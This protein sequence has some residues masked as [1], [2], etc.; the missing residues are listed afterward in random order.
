MSKQTP[1]FDVLIIGG[2]PAGLSLA[3][4][5][6]EHGV[7]VACIDREARQAQLAP[8]F[9]GRTVAISY[10]SRRILEA[11][12]IWAAIDGQ[13]CPI[14]TIRITD[15][16][17]P[18]LVEF[19]HTD[20]P[21]PT[22][23]WIV[24]NRLLRHALFARAAALETVTHIAPATVT[25]L[26]RDEDSVTTQLADGRHIRARLLI[27]ADG[28]GSFVR[29]WM[30]IGTRQWSYKQRAI[31]CTVEHDNPHDFIALENFRPEGPFAV[32]PMT[33]GANGAH[34]SSVVWTE[35]GPERDS[36]Y[37]LD[38]ATFNAAL[39]ARFP[40]FYGSVRQIGVRGCYPL[41]LI[42]AHNYT[43]PR[44]A[45]VGD[46]AHGIH[47]IAG[48]GLNLGFRD[49]AVIAELIVDA[50]NNG[51]DAGADSLLAAYQQRRRLDNMAMAGTT[52]ALTR[53]FSNNIPPVRLLR[54]VGLRLVDRTAPAKK[55]F[56]SQAMGL[57]PVG[58]GVLSGLIPAR[59]AA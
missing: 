2:G 26:L 56:M 37:K 47:P 57:S 35:H 45:L 24:E 23:G 59:D 30:G 48:Q 11:A 34:R 15:G 3:G 9:D 6:G 49:I 53:L 25:A 51:G 38:A 22:F 1:P 52:D 10:G 5:L 43:A 39:T 28:R 27:G 31:T 17:S 7:R 58:G 44:A 42:H 54:R 19:N 20:T 18:T 14:E 32:L 21:A 40:D 33:D 50:V 36:F 4:L 13:T 46:A 16:D 29:E 41:G 12:G 55:F 8:A